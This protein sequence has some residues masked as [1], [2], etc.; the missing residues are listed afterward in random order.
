[1]SLMHL[2][3]FKKHF[4]VSNPQ[5]PRPRPPTRAAQRQFRLVIPPAAL[6]ESSVWGDQRAGSAPSELNTES[7]TFKSLPF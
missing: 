6:K 7:G 2:W 4:H 3:L 1:M 5:T